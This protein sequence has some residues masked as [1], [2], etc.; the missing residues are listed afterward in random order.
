MVLRHHAYR[1]FSVLLPTLLVNYVSNGSEHN[2]LRE[3]H[4]LEQRAYLAEQR[5]RLDEYKPNLF[6]TYTF[7]YCLPEAK[8]VAEV[9]EFLVQAARKLRKHIF[10]F[11]WYDNQPNRGLDGRRYT[12]FHLFLEVEKLNTKFQHSL[13]ELM[14]GG[15]AKKGNVDVREFDPE[16]GAIT[17]S[18]RK[19]AG[20][21]E[22]IACPR[23]KD[24]CN[25]HGRVCAYIWKD[26]LFNNRHR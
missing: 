6:V 24:R 8:A 18:V 5:V 13:C 22:G 2:L 7:R 10:W 3:I 19:H 4:S 9:K 12:H 14:V 21:V 25:K 23:L 11:G 15:W 26:G 17:Y 1:P 16:R 20:Y